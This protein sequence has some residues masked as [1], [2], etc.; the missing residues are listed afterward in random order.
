MEDKSQDTTVSKKAK[1]IRR[2]IGSAIAAI[3][4]VFVLIFGIDRYL[5]ISTDDAFIQAYTTMISSRVGG[6]VEKVLVDDLDD[7]KEGQL[8][9]I[10]DPTEYENALQEAEQDYLAKSAALDGALFYFTRMKK[11]YDQKVISQQEYVEARAK[12]LEA[13][14]DRKSTRAGM[15][16]AQDQLSYTQIKAPTKGGIAKRSVSRGA[17]V[18]PGEPLFGFVEG[19]KRWVIANLKETDLY[20]IRQGMDVKV[21][22][23][24]L[25]NKKL[26][27]TI[28]RIGWATGSTFTLLPP[29]NATGNFVKIVQ[30]VPVLISLVGLND[31]E[32]KQLQVGLSCKVIINYRQ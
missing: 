26:K 31:H 18:A 3:L 11:L 29:D 28:E 5:Y 24:A 7:V 15:A 9:A 17:L 13:L 2:M 19:N 14:A 23:D 27:G 20:R 32:C 22:V 1:R 16:I 6:Y 12:Y 10:V 21:E 30:R 4:I 25:D 8:L